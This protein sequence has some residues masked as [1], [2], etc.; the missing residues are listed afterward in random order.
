MKNFE[1]GEYAVLMEDG[2]R[3]A[4]NK[5]YFVKVMQCV[6]TP[7]LDSEEFEINYIIAPFDDIANTSLV[8]ESNLRKIMKA[9]KFLMHMEKE[10]GRGMIE[11]VENEIKE[12]E[13]KE[14]G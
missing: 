12:S 13:S 6:L 1:N 10:Y 2:F 7:I 4:V 11:E 8:L 5:G 14:G 3:G 9:E